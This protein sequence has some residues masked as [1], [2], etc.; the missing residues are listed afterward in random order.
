MRRHQTLD[1][2]PPPSSSKHKHSLAPQPRG[3][4]LRRL[5]PMDN[6]DTN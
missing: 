6:Q 3:R 4:R 2:R 1:D 5:S